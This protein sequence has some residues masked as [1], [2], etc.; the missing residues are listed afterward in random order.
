MPNNQIPLH[1]PVHVDALVVNNGVGRWK[2]LSLNIDLLN[3]YDSYK[4]LGGYLEKDINDDSKVDTIYEKGIHLHWV[5]PKAFRHGNYNKVTDRLEFPLVPNRWLVIRTNDNMDIKAW[6]VQSDHE[7]NSQSNCNYI[8]ENVGSNNTP[9]SIHPLN[10]GVANDLNVFTEPGTPMFLTV[11]APGN[12]DFAAA[13]MHSKN[14]FGFHDPMLGNDG[15]LLPTGVNYSYAVIG[16]FSDKNADPL[17]KITTKTD[18]DALLKNYSWTLKDNGATTDATVPTAMICHAVKQTVLWSDKPVNNVPSPGGV[19][20]GV[21][22]SS[23]EAL[24]ALLK[25]GI[26]GNQLSVPGKLLA[27]Y[28]YKSLSDNGLG[29][30]GSK[31]LKKQLHNRGFVSVDGGTYWTVEPDTKSG[32]PSTDEDIAFESTTPFDT[33]LSTLLQTLNKQQL[34]YDTQSNQLASK[35]EQ[36]YALKYKR[37]YFDSNNSP[38]DGSAKWANVPAQLDAAIAALKNDIVALRN[39]VIALKSAINTKQDWP[40]GFSGAIVNTYSALQAK[41]ADMKKKGTLPDNY[42][43]KEVPKNKFFEPADPAIVINGLHPAEK[44]STQSATCRTANTLVDTIFTQTQKLNIDKLL[45]DDIQKVIQDANAKSGLKLDGIIKECLL[46]MP[47][48]AK[49]AGALLNQYEGDSEDHTAAIQSLIEQW[50][51]QTETAVFINLNNTAALPDKLS[52]ELWKQPW[53]PLYME[54]NIQWIST[55]ADAS[56]TLLNQSWAFGAGDN[57]VDY[58]LT[59]AASGKPLQYTGRT[60]LAT[61]MGKKVKDL[62][63]KI[64]AGTRGDLFQT[65]QPVSQTLSGFTDQLIM[66]YHGIQLPFFNSD[67]TVDSDYTFI[68]Q[69]YSWSPIA[70]TDNFFAIRS[71]MFKLNMLRVIDTYGQAIDLIPSD[72]D[73]PAPDINNKRLVNAAG[74]PLR[75]VNNDYY[76]VLPPRIVQPARLRFNWV[77][78]NNTSRITD[79]DPGTNPV[80]GWLLHNKLSNSISVFETQGA[81]IAEIVFIGGEVQL[82][83]PLGA[84]TGVQFNNAMLE[85]VVNYIKSSIGNFN[86]MLSTMDNTSRKVQSKASKQ[87]LTMAL[88]LGFPLAVATAQTSLELKELPAQQQGWT[89]PA[90]SFANNRY[91]ICIGDAGNTLD[92]LAGYFIDNDFTTFHQPS[93]VASTTNSIAASNNIDIALNEVH[94]MVLLLDPRSQFYISPGI[95]PSATYELPQNAVMKPLQQIQLRFPVA[96]VIT[97]ATSLTIP[98]LQSKDVTWSFITVTGVQQQTVQESDPV[99]ANKDLLSFGPLYAAEGWLKATPASE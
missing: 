52:V 71:G 89:A 14:V 44:F 85:K 45:T 33:E 55:Y 35:Q 56:N 16:W 19:T 69:H 36:L 67:L 72:N 70:D 61:D 46:F 17:A 97:P 42:A 2:D 88:P 24:A 57:T 27:A 68:D 96:P 90:A 53:T 41:L 3:Y 59:A 99:T 74:L 22:N 48:I 98:L 7:N 8:K 38:S 49:K 73:M 62:D 29:T 58:A 50:H 76:F 1:V 47:T 60:I 11:M 75:Q 64:D 63:D 25:T 23:A 81:A 21:G 28:Q 78:G 66:R 77:S 5:L 4:A 83:T 51:D 32:E 39:A 94:N 15:K 9:L 40:A 95:L 80:C 31:P 91:T 93:G 18:L 13:Y 79:A 82:Q 6:V 26:S 92:G 30:D 34:D 10:I 37:L 65:M 12:P 84:N 54:W 87:Q 20:I 86:A 43:I